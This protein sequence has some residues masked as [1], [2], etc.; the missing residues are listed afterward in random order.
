MGGAFKPGDKITKSGIY[1]V[2]HEGKHTDAHEATCIA[3]K[4]FPPCDECGDG[5]RFALVKHARLVTRHD[6]FRV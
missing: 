3:G 2:A 1:S 5:V 6:H 4:T